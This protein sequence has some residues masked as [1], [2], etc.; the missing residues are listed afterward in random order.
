MLQMTLNEGLCYCTDF[1]ACKSCGNVLFKTLKKV[2]SSPFLVHFQSKNNPVMIIIVVHWS[3][4]ALFLTLK[5]RLVGE[6]GS[7]RVD[8]KITLFCFCIS[9]NFM[10]RLM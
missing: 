5:D 8:C 10:F 9:L 2:T 3:C 4:V 7:L 1:P 6:M